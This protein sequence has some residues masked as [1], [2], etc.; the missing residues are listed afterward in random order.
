MFS[1]LDFR[2]DYYRMTNREYRFSLRFII[3][4]VFRHNVRFMYWVRKRT[5]TNSFLSKVQLY[6]YSRKF[7]LEVSPTAVF[8][9]GV[10][11]G[12]PYN[13]TIGD[14]V[15]LGR[16]V[17]IH[18]GA[19][20]GVENRGKRAGSPRIGNN[21]YIGINATVTGNIQIGD[22][23]MIAPGAFVNFDVPEHSIV[24]GNPAVVHHRENATEGYI[25]C[26]I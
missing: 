24:V 20:I 17:N 21:V 6:R 10:Y 2:A 26:C 16:N 9:P 14:G 13:I 23:V 18:K 7:G 15:R 25:R 3:D 12:H 8:G 19:T 4:F 11:L 22:D 1:D 5:R